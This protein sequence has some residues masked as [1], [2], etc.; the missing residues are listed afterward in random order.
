M[1]DVKVGNVEIQPL[2]D[3]TALMNPRFMFPKVADEMLA[4]YPQYVVDQ[5]RQLLDLPM[6]TFLLRSSGKTILVDTGIGPRRRS[7]MPRGK[8][9]ETLRDAGVARSEID[10]VV[11]THLHIDHVGWNTVDNERG[12]PEVFFPNARFVIQRGEWDFWME[13]ERL[14]EEDNAHLRE[15]VEP[16]RHSGRIDFVEG[17]AAFDENL[18]FLSTPGHTPGHVSIGIASAGE[19]AIIVGDASHHP[20]QLEHPDWSPNP[21]I[22]PVLSAKTRDRLFDEVADDG[23]MWIAGHWPYPGM[24]HIQRVDGKR[25]F[26]AL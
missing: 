1:H 14:Q 24:G 6:V 4:G 15:C 17:E 13:T 3:A 23:R 16:L 19:R 11:H 20:A 8:L 25:V 5:E 12:E 10:A 21:D 26:K 7:G 18:T 9:D 2:R 22:D